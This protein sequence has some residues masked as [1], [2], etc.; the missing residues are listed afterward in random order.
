MQQ[1]YQHFS[2]CK[3]SLLLKCLGHSNSW[4][5]LHWSSRPLTLALAPLCPLLAG[6]LTSPREYYFPLKTFCF[7]G[8]VGAVLVG[9]VSSLRGLTSPTL[10]KEVLGLLLNG[11]KTSIMFLDTASSEE[12]KFIVKDAIHIP[13]EKKKK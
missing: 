6:S 10:S 2:W 5:W 1:F 9:S 8:L 4:S 7:A 3:G 11:Q 13:Q 12:S